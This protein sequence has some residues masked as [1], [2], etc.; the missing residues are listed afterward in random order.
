ML[1]F[2]TAKI[3]Q[4]EKRDLISPIEENEISGYVSTPYEGHPTATELSDRVHADINERHARILS[5]LIT[6]TKVI[7]P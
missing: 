2:Y 5:V 3:T 1:F 7:S 6:D 4:R